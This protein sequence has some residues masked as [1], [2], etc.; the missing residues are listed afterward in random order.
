MRYNYYCRDK[1]CTVDNYR[2]STADGMTIRVR[3]GDDI[4]SQPLV[5]E[6][7]H[8]MHEAPIVKCPACGGIAVKHL[9]FNTG[10][11]YIRGNGFLDRDGCRRE[12]ALHHLE[13]KD[14]DGTPLNPYEEHYQ[15]G[16]K[17]H[18]RQML[19]RGGKPAPVVTSVSERRH[20]IADAKA[21]YIKTVLDFIGKSTTQVEVD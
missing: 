9:G 16:E 14:E 17:D 12:M 10:T 19:K 20:R 1:E 6:E 3:R 13:G 11:F 7:C 18:I 5:W 2:S 15:S 21:E 4:G 8:G